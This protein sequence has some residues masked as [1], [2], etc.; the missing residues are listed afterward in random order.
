MGDIHLSG[1]E[2]TVL[3]ALMGAEPVPGQPL[4]GAHVLEMLNAL[5]PCDQDTAR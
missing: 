5:V 1:R 3:R 4:P 2:L